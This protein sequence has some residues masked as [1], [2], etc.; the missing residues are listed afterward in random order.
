[1]ATEVLRQPAELAA[2]AAPVRGPIDRIISIPERLPGP[3]LLWYAAVVPV[4]AVV[5]SIPSWVAGAGAFGSVSEDFVAPALLAAYLLGLI[6]V[7]N[8]IA[9][10]SFE[11]FRDALDPHAR[12]EKLAAELTSIPDRAAI[13][14]IAIAEVLLT[15]GFLTNGGQ[16]DR[17]RL[18]PP[19]LAAAE[20]IAWW[21]AIAV[22]ALVVLHTV[23]QL[24]LITRLHAAA[25]SIDLFDR[26]AIVAFSRLTSATAIGLLVIPILSIA[27]VS[28]QTTSQ[29]T[30]FDLAQEA[31]LVLLAAAAFVLPLLGMHDRMAREKGR[32]LREVNERLKV[33]TTRIHDGVDADHLA[34]ADQLNKTLNSL[35]AEREVIGR[36]STWPWSPNTLRGFGSA[37]LLPIVI[38]L[39]IRFL[40]RVI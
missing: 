17:L 19:S 28:G 18:L 7:L 36:F 20:F 3:A 1:M 32:L 22:V 31:S 29:P 39:L 8:R 5:L 40:E 27:S 25:T 14:A 30:A 11:D 33:T 37:I 24:R 13:L 12:Q 35:L 26:S 10:G 6:H 34:D 23:R 21:I 38:W 2:E 4:V 9:R 15:L 16:R